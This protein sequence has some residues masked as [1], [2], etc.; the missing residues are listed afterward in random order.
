MRTAS[1]CFL[2]V[3]G[4][5]LAGL[6]SSCAAQAQSHPFTP[7]MSCAAA[8]RLVAT[9]GAL[10]LSTGADLYDRYVA[11][12]AYCQRDEITKPTWVPAADTPQCFV[13]YRCERIGDEWPF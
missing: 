1:R 12:Q 6:G 3:A 8:S 9:K 13:G 7:R 10:I 5:A 11:S 4:M 2:I